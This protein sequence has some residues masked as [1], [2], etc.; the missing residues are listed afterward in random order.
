MAEVERALGRSVNYVLYDRAEFEAKRSAGEGFL[1][2]V[3][4]GP[5]IPLV[6]DVGGSA[7]A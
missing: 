4:K 5:V 1:A 2:D 7:R 6:G 3:L